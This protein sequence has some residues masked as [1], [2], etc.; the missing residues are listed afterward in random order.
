MKSE[1]RAHF[2]RRKSGRAYGLWAGSVIRG[3]YLEIIAK[4]LEAR[5]YYGRPADIREEPGR[6]CKQP[7]PHLIGRVCDNADGQ[8]YQKRDGEAGRQRLTHI[9]SQR[10]RR[11]QLLILLLPDFF[12]EKRL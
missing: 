10:S 1:F 12:Q 9:P 7:R 5:W 6:V 11:S 4:R 8:R 2:H 3:I